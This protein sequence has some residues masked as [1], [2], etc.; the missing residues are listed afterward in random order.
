MKIFST[1]NLTFKRQLTQC[2]TDEYKNILREGKEKVGN[3]GRSMLIVPT[4]S[5]PEKHS[6]SRGVGNFLDSTSK[7][8]ID[9]AKLYW[10][11]NYIQLLP[12][13][14]YYKKNGLYRPFSGGALDLGTQNINFELLTQKEYGEILTPKDLEKIYNA[15]FNVSN[16]ILANFDNVLLKDSEADVIL[17]NAYKKLCLADTEERRELIREF[18]QF[19]LENK[20]WLEPKG[21]FRALE[22]KNKTSFIKGWKDYT[23]QHLYDTDIVDLKKREETIKELLSTEAGEE[24]DLYE[25]KQFIADKHIAKAKKILNDKGIKL[26]GDMPSGYSYVEKWANPKA[27]IPDT[28][29]R[30]GLPALNLDSAEGKEY[31]RLKVRNFAKRYDGFRVDAGWTYIEQ[32]LHNYKTNVYSKKIYNSKIL[33]IIEDEVLKIKGM[34]YNLENITYEFEADSKDYNIFDRYA[35]KPEVKNR[36][37]IYKTNHLNNNWGTYNAY[38]KM[39][40]SPNSYILGTTN[41][42]AEPMRILYENVEKRNEQISVLSKILKIPVEKFKTFGDFAQ[43]K[44]AEPLQCKNNMF[45]FSEILNI[46][47]RFKD[48]PEAFRDKDYRLKIPENYKELYFKSLENGEG[49]NPMDALEKLFIAKGYDK[50]SPDLYKKIVKY[51]KILQSKEKMRGSSKTLI[52][53]SCA[54]VVTAFMT[55]L[56]IIKKPSRK[57]QS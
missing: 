51:N 41:H 56:A 5:L 53:I 49:Y 27:F 23:E 40:W 38:Y 29:I 36:V 1:H 50:E 48:N 7:E 11:I 35:L 20:E 47:G 15:N 43:A 37:K 22:A 42:D 10:G 39:G 46:N 18:E 9:F 32:P 33:D 3:T 31:L 24:K 16:D 44:F 57:E 13:G 26:S 55:Y 8:F 52:Y 30:W 6:S 2:E 45:F 19:K 28:E 17:K 21:V 54:L 14:T 12:D 34:D 25:F 4:T